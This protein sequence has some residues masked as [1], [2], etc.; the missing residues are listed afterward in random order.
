ML[1]GDIFYMTVLMG[2]WLAATFGAA[3]AGERTN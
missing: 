3:Q 2:C 1:S